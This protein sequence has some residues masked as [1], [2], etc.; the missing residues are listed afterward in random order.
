MDS[1]YNEFI[2]NYSYDVFHVP[3]SRED[4]VK[5]LFHDYAKYIS[6]EFEDKTAAMQ[7]REVSSTKCYLCHK[8]L[9]K[10]MKPFMKVVLKATFMPDYL[11]L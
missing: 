6:R 9:K 5:V 3:Q 2:E 11:C 4:E 8:N 10:K 1:K 7:D